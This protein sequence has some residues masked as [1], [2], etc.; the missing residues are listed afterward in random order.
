M[1]LEVGREREM[2][3]TRTTTV[4][5]FTT[6]RVVE[7]LKQRYLSDGHCELSW[8]QTQRQAQR[9]KGRMEGAAHVHK[10]EAKQQAHTVDTQ[11]P[12]KTHTTY[13]VYL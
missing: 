12:S 9:K 11:S 10:Y 8:R 4:L 1:R 2:W 7:S 5:H 6:V 13:R 3:D